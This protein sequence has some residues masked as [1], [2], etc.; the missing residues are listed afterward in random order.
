MKKPIVTSLIFSFI[1]GFSITSLAGWQD[2]LKGASDSA[3]KILKSD[4]AVDTAK[5]VLSNDDVIAGLKEAL[6]VGSKKAVDMLGKEGG[7][8]NDDKV[9]IPMPEKL[10]QAEKLLRTLGQDELADEF[11]E[12]MNHAAEQAVPKTTEIFGNAIQNMSIEDAKKILQGKNNAA[13]QYFR[14]TTYKDLAKAI[15][16]IVKK[17]TEETGVTSVY[18]KLLDKANS[19]NVMGMGMSDVVDP[20]SFDLD[21]YVTK[22]TLNGLFYKL[23]QEE[24][25]IRQDPVARTTDLLKKVFSQI[26]Q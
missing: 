10:Q 16:P 12:T 22:Q 3:D 9:K 7:F 25:L 18:K 2:W 19:V 13:T 1:L 4:S 23:A 14:R 17:T 26:A 8:L 21:T 20:K 6:V 24:K 11:I 5:Q 15:R